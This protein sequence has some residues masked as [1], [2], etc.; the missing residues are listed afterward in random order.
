MQDGGRGGGRPSGDLGVGLEAG[1]LHGVALRLHQPDDTL[2]G[3]RV[4]GHTLLSRS[5][6]SGQQWVSHTVTR[7]CMSASVKTM[8]SNTVDN[9][10]LHMYVFCAI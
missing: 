4:V 6:P 8:Y 7:A 3:A 10:Y 2:L 1:R 5:V 9:R